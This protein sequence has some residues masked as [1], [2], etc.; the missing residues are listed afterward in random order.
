[1][2]RAWIVW[3][4][5]AV[6]LSARSAGAF[7]LKKAANG[8]TV[9]WGGPTMTFVVDPS[10]EAAVPGGGAAV[11]SALAAWSGVSGAP[12]LTWTAG[13]GGG[14][15]AVDGVNTV[16]LAP[17]GF[18]PAGAAL[19]VTVVTF[20]DDTGEILDADIVVNGVYAFAVL[21]A[22]ARSAGAAPMPLE[23]PTSFD[24]AAG[25]FDILH[26]LAHETGHA[27]GLGD[28]ST[29]DA[30]M[31]LYTSAGD[32]A[33][34]GPVSDDAAGLE[35]LY[36]ER[37]TGCSSASVAGSPAGERGDGLVTVALALAAGWA[38]RR[39]GGRQPGR[40]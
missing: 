11:A 19:A 29:D 6:L 3:V 12:E 13:P 23:G 1:M 28:V 25:P 16:L 35:A 21:A 9:H 2:A 7:E 30:V 5:V 31:Y 39:R 4:V 40:S 37:R 14:K 26:V 32:A 22:D 20:D 36:G 10:L 27:L 17:E 24:P 34:R 38:M 8:Q 33:Y 15:A 18:A